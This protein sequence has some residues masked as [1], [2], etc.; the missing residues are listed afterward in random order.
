MGNFNSSNHTGASAKRSTESP[1]QQ[2]KETAETQQ[3]RQAA[4]KLALRKQLEKTL[5]QVTSTH[6]IF[7][8]KI[9]WRCHYFQIPPPK[10]P[11]PE[12]HF[13]PNPAN[14]EFIYLCGLEECVSRILDLDAETPVQPMPFVCSQ[15]GTDFT[16]TWKWDKAAKGRSSDDFPPAHILQN[17]CCLIRPPLSIEQKVR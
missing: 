5:L 9:I 15:C 10:P 8:L 4:A 16:P 17:Y 12:M 13:I 1:V 3:Q 14:T 11:P 7:S 2:K 6:G